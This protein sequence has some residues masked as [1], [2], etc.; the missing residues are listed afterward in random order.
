LSDVT[1][2]GNS[3]QSLLTSNLELLSS[4]ALLYAGVGTLS[5]VNISIFVV[6][7]GFKGLNVILGPLQGIVDFL[8]LSTIFIVAQAMLLSFM[9]YVAPAILL[10]LGIILRTFYFTRKLGGTIIAIAIGGFLILPMTYVL[11]ATL[12]DTYFINSISTPISTTVSSINTFLSSAQSLQGSALSLGTTP[13]ANKINWGLVNTVL[14]G[15]GILSSS[16][17]LLLTT[18][19]S[20]IVL[21]IIQVFFLPAFSI[22]L[23]FVSTKELAKIFGSELS[24]DMF[25][26]F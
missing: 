22:V 7:F 5:S 16:F 26:V 12:M 20:S 2:N 19:W 14:S 4:T 13:S 9:Y 24:L 6:S 18:I 15:I 21:T 8:S 10:P 1:I 11:S 23:T 17:N 25:N 3:Y